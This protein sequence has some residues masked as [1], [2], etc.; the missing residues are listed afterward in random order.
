MRLCP[1]RI[2]Y[3]GTPDFAVP[4][5]EALLLNKYDVAAVYTQPD[6]PA[7]RGQRLVLPPVKQLAVDW[8][9]PVSM[10]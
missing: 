2:I 3:M 6:K 1:V 8:N 7:G 4:S 10:L 9:L 5:L